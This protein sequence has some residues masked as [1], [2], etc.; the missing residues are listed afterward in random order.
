M[1]VIPRRFDAYTVFRAPRS[2]RALVGR[3]PRILSEDI[4][5]KLIWAGLNITAD[6]PSVQGGLSHYYPVPFVRAMSA[7]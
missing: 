7:V 1:E 6:D 2:L 3:D 4:W 5:A